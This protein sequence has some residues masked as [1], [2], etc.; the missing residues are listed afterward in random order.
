MNGLTQKRRNVAES[1]APAP[2]VDVVVGQPSH[3]FKEFTKP[4]SEETSNAGVSNVA[5]VASS[6]NAATPPKP[7]SV[8]KTKTTPDREKSKTPLSDVKST[9]AIAP[10]PS[11]TSLTVNKNGKVNVDDFVP[12]QNAID[13]F[14]DDDVQPTSFGFNVANADED[15]DD[16]DDEN[17]N[18]MVAGFTD[19]LDLDDF[20]SSVVVASSSDDDSR[21]VKTQAPV[22]AKSFVVESEP[23]KTKAKSA[24]NLFAVD[25][26]T[27]TV[28]LASESVDDDVDVEPKKKHKKKKS[29]KRASKSPSRERDDLED[30]LNGSPESAQHRDAAVYEEL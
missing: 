7:A 29:K 27:Q 4:K 19:D 17:Y 8:A 30:F 1:L 28:E 9:Q 2:T 10:S 3:T 6:L 5:A 24:K 23:K 20:K 21:A 18:P 12:D 16:D 15:A 25:L 11:Q 13:N 26:P 14:L 22:V